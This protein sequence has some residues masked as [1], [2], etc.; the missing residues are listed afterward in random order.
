MYATYWMERTAASAVCGHW[1]RLVVESNLCSLLT[2]IPPLWMVSLKRS[3]NLEI[4]QIR[5][6]EKSVELAGRYF[7]MTFF[8]ELLSKCLYLLQ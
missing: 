7:K 2:L 6:L 8:S 5:N 1:I 3:L 4:V